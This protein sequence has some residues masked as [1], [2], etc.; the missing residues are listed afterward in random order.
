MI[1]DEPQNQPEDVRPPDLEGLIGKLY[2]DSKELVPLTV[3]IPRD[4]KLALKMR[5]LRSTIQ[6][7][8]EH[9]YLLYLGRRVPK[10]FIAPFVWPE[11]FIKQ[12]EPEYLHTALQSLTVRIPRGLL[13]WSRVFAAEEELSDQELALRV[14][15]HYVRENKYPPNKEDVRRDRQG[16]LVVAEQLVGR[17]FYEPTRPVLRAA[18]KVLADQAERVNGAITF[19]SHNS[20][21]RAVPAGVSERRRSDRKPRSRSGKRHASRNP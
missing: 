3:R 11:E 7:L 4:L 18:F 20:D 9:A 1:E 17:P 15:D 10:R 21:Q 12:P 16:F 2:A 5:A 13:R 8:A 6:L 19:P 14:F